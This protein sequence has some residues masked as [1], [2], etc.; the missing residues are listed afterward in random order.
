MQEIIIIFLV[1][2]VIFLTFKYYTKKQ[3]TYERK[4]FKIPISKLEDIPDWLKS[5]DSIAV[6][7]IETITHDKNYNS[8]SHKYELELYSKFDDVDD[9]DYDWLV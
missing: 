1:C 4:Y 8:S 5:Y 2:L 7:R 3:K 9:D 6:T